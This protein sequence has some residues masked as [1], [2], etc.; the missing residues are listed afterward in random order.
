[1]RRLHKLPVKTVEPGRER[2]A[3][4]LPHDIYDAPDGDTS[5][6]K[7][8]GRP[9][10]ADRPATKAT[11]SH[12]YLERAAI[13]CE[14]VLSRPRSRAALADLEALAADIRRR[15]APVDSKLAG[16][17]KRGRP[18]PLGFD[19][20]LTDGTVQRCATVAEA[21]MLYG[22]KPDS[23]KAMLAKGGAGKCS[24]I[25]GDSS[26]WCR[27]VYAVEDGSTSNQI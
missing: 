11:L 27:R 12:A 16:P 17:A 24:R 20:G 9:R 15:L 26:M 3:R 22:V 6:R 10:L 23:L 21:A 25:V 19:V 18:G 7:K 2:A 14:A 5:P 4:T 13:V 1:M 8:P